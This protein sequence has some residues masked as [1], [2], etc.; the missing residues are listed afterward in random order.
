MEKRA[1]TKN[2]EK[3]ELTIKLEHFIKLGHPDE[4]LFTSH[5][6]HYY[7]KDYSFTFLLIFNKLSIIM[8]QSFPTYLH[9]YGPSSGF[10]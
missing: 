9:S 2:R 7:E 10:H 6:L 8:S 4:I 3:S 5:P 1:K